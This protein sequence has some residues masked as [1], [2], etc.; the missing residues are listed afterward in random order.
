MNKITGE[1][2][3][4]ELFSCKTL[5]SLVLHFREGDETIGS[6][7][8]GNFLGRDEKIIELL[9]QYDTFLADHLHMFGNSG[10]NILHRLISPLKRL[11]D[12]SS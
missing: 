7:R 1:K 9:A 11:M 4:A 12:L 10:T 3:C 6:K 5:A 2:F 8:N